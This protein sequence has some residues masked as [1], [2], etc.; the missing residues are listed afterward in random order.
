MDRAYSQFA[1]THNGFL[2]ATLP[3]AR[4]PDPYFAPWEAI[5]AN[6]PLLL[7]ESRLRAAVHGLD[8]LDA[9]R[10]KTEDEWRRA[11]VI[12]AFLTHAYI[13][14]DDDVADVRLSRRFH[15]DPLAHG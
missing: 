9:G 14:G 4:L 12:L 5:I 6:L 10:L 11:C 8:T 13:W 7:R 3:L 2:P 15:A 1:L